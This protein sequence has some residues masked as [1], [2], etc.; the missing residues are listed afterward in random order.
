MFRGLRGLVVE[1]IAERDDGLVVTL[2]TSGGPAVCPMCATPSAR[3]HDRAVRCPADLPVAGVRVEL[4]VR[5]RR[6]IC[7]VAACPRRTFREQIPGVLERYQRRTARLHAAL[8]TLTVELAGRATVRVAPGLGIDLR[9]D[10]AL[11]VLRSVALPD[12][13]VPRV[14]GIDDFALRRG[15]VYATVL[16]DAETGRRVDVVEGRGA[17]VV[18]AWLREHPGVQVVTRDGSTVYAQAVREALPHAVQVA[19]RW[20]LWH[21][22]AD[23]AGKEVAAHA[24]CWAAAAATG[25]R[26]GRIAETTAQ[27]WAQVRELRDA[28]VGLLDCSRRLGIALNTVKRY[29]RAAK[30]EQITRPPRYRTTLVDPHRDH[31]RQRR[32]DDPGVS[33]QQL[34]TEIRALGYAGSQN[35]LY[36]YLNQQRHLDTDPHLSPRRATRLMLTRPSNLTERQT[37]RLARLVAACPEMTALG[38]LVRS[39]AALL[40]PDPANADA[41]TVWL[42]QARAL[43][44]PHVHSF[45]RGVEQDHDA[46]VAALTTSYHNGRTEGVNTRTKMLKRQMYGRAGFDLLRHRIL[47]T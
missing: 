14:L 36:R 31:L 43:D 17:D 9:R 28:G 1:D 37:T 6:L 12:L 22:L 23:A 33:V 34:L 19:D 41:L 20:H 26:T 27:R 11:R 45:V 7:P 24:A 40:V 42:D 32:Q 30:P 16:I 44:L 2:V 13:V 29:D 47:H 5:V 21:N 38:G 25:M 10:T 46:V 35:L 3:V 39:F 8:E 4:R 15:Q 18:T